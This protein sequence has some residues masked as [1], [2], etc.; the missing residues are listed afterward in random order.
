MQ[1]LVG[2]ILVCVIMLPACASNTARPRP[3]AG[4]GRVLE[5]REGLA[6]YYADSFQGKMTAS[7]VRFDTKAMVAAHPT[8]PFGTRVRV[9]S[10][11]T[12]R[13][14]QVV[15]IDRGPAR[16]PRAQGVIIDLSRNAAA[17]LGFIQAGLTKVRLEVLSWGK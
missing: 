17:R 11:A 13:S 15:V 2:A 14:V 10:L 6:S 16:G 9:T 1:R 5:L 8:Y 7:G 3:A 4:A 12:K